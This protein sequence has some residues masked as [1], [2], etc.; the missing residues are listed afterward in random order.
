MTIVELLDRMR[1]SF[2][3]RLVF[4]EP[5]EQDGLTV[6][7]AAR[8]IGGGGGGTGHDRAGAR[9]NGGGLGLV[10]KPVGAFVIRDGQVRWVPAVDVNQ[11]VTTL[12]GAVLGGL[13]LRGRRARRLRR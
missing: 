4:S 3:A 6:I 12:V 10:T 8:V 13:L 9:G 2:T 11:L 1:D 5:H 7:P